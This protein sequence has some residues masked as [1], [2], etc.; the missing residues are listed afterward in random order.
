MKRIERKKK[1]SAKLWEARVENIE[2]GIR[3]RQEKRQD[4]IMKRKKEKKLYKMKKAANKGRVM[5]GF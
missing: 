1:K 2:N 3:E 5:P 4:N